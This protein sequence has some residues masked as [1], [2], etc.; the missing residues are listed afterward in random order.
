MR[1]H[2]LHVESVAWITERKD[3]LSTLFGLLSLLAYVSYA[4]SRGGWSFA[5][6][7]LCFV[8][9]L[10]SKQTLVTLPFVFLL[11]D[12][13]PLG[14]FAERSARVPLVVEK[15]PFLAVSAAFSAITIIAQKSGQA[16]APLDALPLTARCMNAAH[17][18]CDISAAGFFP[19]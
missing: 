2:P 16:V 5:A 19:V 11:L 7:L 12:F 17:R 15:I 6:C 1:L 9:S 14:R 3:V 8:A 13:W 4:K 10:L 18:L